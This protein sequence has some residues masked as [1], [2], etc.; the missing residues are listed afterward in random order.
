MSA[1][2]D[3]VAQVR[4]GK[5]QTFGFL[6]GQI[7]KQSGGKANPKVVNQLLRREIRTGLNTLSPFFYRLSAVSQS[8]ILAATFFM[9][10][11]APTTPA[12]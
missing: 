11:P 1:H 7:M 4:A 10:P 9:R 6:V 12:A 5:Q 3:A 2:P 8:A